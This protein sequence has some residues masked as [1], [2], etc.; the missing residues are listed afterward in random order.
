MLLGLKTKITDMIFKD[1]HGDS[2]FSY[3]KTGPRQL[4]SRAQVPEQSNMLSLGFKTV[5]L[6]FF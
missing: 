3:P 1:L 6:S 4:T 2:S 5:N